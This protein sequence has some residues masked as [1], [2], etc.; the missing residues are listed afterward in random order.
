LRF[1]FALAVFMLMPLAST[2]AAAQAPIWYWCDALHGYYPGVRV[3]PGG[4]RPVNPPITLPQ[5]YT[6]VPQPVAPPAATGA[7]DGYRQG[8]A[9]WRTLQAWFASQTGD[10]RAGADFWAANRSKAVHRSCAD[11][12][13]N[14]PGDKAA[15]IAGCQE[16]KRQLDLI[17]AKRLSEP[18]YRAGFND[19]AKQ[20]PLSTDTTSPPAQGVPPTAAV[21]FSAY[22]L[23]G[24]I[25]IGPHAPPDL[26]TAQNYLFRTRITAASREPPNFASRY[27]ISAWGCGTGCAQGVAVNVATGKVIW[28]PNSFVLKPLDAERFEYRIDSRL[29]VVNGH[30]SEDDATPYAPRCYVLD[31]EAYPRLV[32]T[33]CHASASATTSAS[34]ALPAPAT[35]SPIPPQASVPAP[36]SMPKEGYGGYVQNTSPTPAPLPPASKPSTTTAPSTLSPNGAPAVAPAQTNAGPPKPLPSPSHEGKGSVLKWIAAI[37]LL[38]VTISSIAGYFIYRIVKRQQLDGGVQQH[39][40]DLP[41]VG[42][43]GVVSLP[44][45]NGQGKVRTGGRVWL[46]EGPNLPKDAE[47]IIK[48]VQGTRIIVEEVDAKQRNVAV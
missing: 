13:D 2:G 43:E 34:T 14:F 8:V 1:R 25:Y 5:P 27:V 33:G 10:S 36:P 45:V 11:A 39:P 29:L 21:S 12:G 41:A 17:D 35:A 18:Q 44:I 20:L 7:T 37:A 22:S 42:A 28:L 23:P 9:D 40:G 15:F 30:D 6:A 38:L 32:K 31:D 3:C 19:E 4:W 26:S 47:V 48:S 24:P 16:S 46:V